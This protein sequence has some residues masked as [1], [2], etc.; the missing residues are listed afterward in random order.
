MLVFFIVRYLN[1]FLTLSNCLLHIHILK[2]LRRFIL[3][4]MFVCVYLL[5]TSIMLINS[6]VLVIIMELDASR[7]TQDQCL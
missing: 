6:L 2:L 1:N 3:G 4:I 5:L 7:S